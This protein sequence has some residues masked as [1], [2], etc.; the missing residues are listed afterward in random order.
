LTRFNLDSLYIRNAG[1]FGALFCLMPSTRMIVEA[2]A[3]CGNAALQPFAP[4]KTS[5][6]I[7][8]WLR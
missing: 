7:R 8:A 5:D 4:C 6:R 2:G 1:A 3:G